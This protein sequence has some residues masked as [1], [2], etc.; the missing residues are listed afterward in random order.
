MTFVS[1]KRHFVNKLMRKLWIVRRKET[2]MK[3]RV[4]ERSMIYIIR[5]NSLRNIMF[6]S[7]IQG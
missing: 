1:K 6:K 2:E 4:N 7:D 5:L 3:N